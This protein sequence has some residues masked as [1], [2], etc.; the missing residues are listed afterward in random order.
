MSQHGKSGC[1]SRASS[2]PCLLEKNWKVQLMLV[3][4]PAYGISIQHGI[5]QILYENLFIFKLIKSSD[6]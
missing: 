5:N 3:F 1:G 6:I 2:R 4:V